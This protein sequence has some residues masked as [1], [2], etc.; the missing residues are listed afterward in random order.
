MFHD[1]EP[2]AWTRVALSPC[3]L[4]TDHPDVFDATSALAFDHPGVTLHT[5]LYCEADSPTV[6]A[7]VGPDALGDHLQARLG[8][9]PGMDRPCRR[10][11]GGRDQRIRRDRRQGVPL[12]AMRLAHGLRVRP[13]PCLSRCWRHRR[14]VVVGLRQQRRLE[15]T[16]SVE[17]RRRGA[18]QHDARR[19]PMAVDAP[20]VP[21]G[22]SGVCALHGAGTT[23]VSSRPATPQTSPAGG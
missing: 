12:P 23:S 22:Y 4:H 8:Q 18:P 11:T 17:I 1:P 21:H 9:R 10:S 14:V 6:R 20:M 2:F 5:H 19:G 3:G 16:G 15:P 7:A 13:H